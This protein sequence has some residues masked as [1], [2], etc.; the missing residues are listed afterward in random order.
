MSQCIDLTN[1]QQLKEI[2]GL[3]EDII[4]NQTYTVRYPLE[5][6]TAVVYYPITGSTTVSFTLGSYTELEFLEVFTSVI[7]SNV[8]LV[9][10]EEYYEL[11]WNNG[12]GFYF[13]EQSDYLKEYHWF[14]P[15]EHSEKNRFPRNHL[16]YEDCTYTFDTNVTELT[17]E[18][19]CTMNFTIQ[20]DTERSFTLPQY[21]LPMN[22]TSLTASI[23]SL[24][25]AEMPV[26]LC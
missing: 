15:Y 6:C 13:N 2:L 19:P 23:C 5:S 1:A 26:D 25:N 22:T 4:N 12:F 20:N 9:T 24:I 17:T 8:T 18:A 21:T 11:V 10:T 7:S 14:K 3:H 16:R